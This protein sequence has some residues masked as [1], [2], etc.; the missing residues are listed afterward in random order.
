VWIPSNCSL[1]QGPYLFEDRPPTPKQEK[2]E[3]KKPDGQEPPKKK[4]MNL[5]WDDEGEVIHKTEGMKKI[6]IQHILD[7]NQQYDSELMSKI[8]KEKDAAEKYERK[9]QKV[10]AENGTVTEVPKGPTTLKRG[11]FK[12]GE[13][14]DLTEF[15]QGTNKDNSVIGSQNKGNSNNNQKKDQDNQDGDGK[16]QEKGKNKNKKHKNKEPGSGTK[17]AK[18]NKSQ[19][20]K[21]SSSGRPTDKD[22]ESATGTDDKKSDLQL[23]E[24]MKPSPQPS[25]PK[26]EPKQPVQTPQ[27]APQPPKPAKKPAGPPQPQQPAYLG[28]DP[29]D[30]PP[31]GMRPK[32]PP[33]AGPQLGHGGQLPP[34]S[35]STQELQSFIREQMAPPGMYYAPPQPYLPGDR[36]APPHPHAHPHGPQYP[37]QPM[38]PGYGRP[39]PE[40]LGYHAPQPL[41]GPPYYP[42]PGPMHAPHQ[43]GGYYMLPERGPS[44]EQLNDQMLKQ[45]LSIEKPQQPQ[46]KKRPPLNPNPKPQTDN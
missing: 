45:M 18:D 26:R 27:P 4:K 22:Q 6:D 43:H 25:A 19:K 34:G 23:S 40:D 38:Y 11:A 28:L 15:K 12:R 16:A 3:E 9:V 17:D 2:V 30:G 24:P 35:L 8:Q 29:L 41:Y 14:A 1:T 10:N 21:D 39:L 13:V 32:K 37:L 20:E 44:L 36:Y 5:K 7:F 46:T 33:G 31:K 42:P